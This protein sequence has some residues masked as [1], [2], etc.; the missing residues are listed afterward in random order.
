MPRGMGPA[1]RAG[2]AGAVIAAG[3]GLGA[4]NPWWMAAFIGIPLILAG[5]LIAPRPSR[6]SGL[7]TYRAGVSDRFVPA[8]V[9]ALTRSTLANEDQQPTLVTATI[10][11]AND[12]SY[13]ARWMTAMSRK[14]FQALADNPLTSLPPDGLPPRESR[15]SPDFDDHPGMRA[16]IYPAITVVTALAVL[17]A[18]G[19]VWRVSVRLP[20]LPVTASQIT[21]KTAN[22]DAR[23]D[24]M[25]RAITEKLG[26][27]AADNLLDLR[28]S[29][30]GS[31]YGSVLNPTNGESTTVYINNGRDTYTSATPN[32]LRKTSTFTARD[33]ASIQ[34]TTIAERMAQ[35]FRAVGNDGNLEDFQIK[36]SGPAKPIILTGKFNVPNTFPFPTTIQARPDGTVA[37]LFDPADFA[38]AFKRA[39]QALELAGI[40]ASDPVLTSF[41][42]RGIVRNTPHLHASTIQNSG[43]VLIEFRSDHRKGEAVV[44]PG[45]LPEVVDRSWGSNTPG[46]SF[47]D[48]SLT[49]FESVRRQA[50]HRGSLE[51]YESRAVDIEMSDETSDGRG[52]AIRIQ[53]AN[54]DAAAGTYSPTGEFLQPG[55]R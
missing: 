22:L 47:D 29:D 4:F 13:R 48:V 31:D 35:Q 43:G 55:T 19:D 50:M 7:T 45:E 38:E 42:I 3:I 32:T 36:R 24:N 27:G 26:P 10:S 53:L 14:D 6:I 8:R 34:L 33:V 5:L 11:P 28:F 37:E 41:Q 12:T 9:E 17:F 52:L 23:R 54:V 51:P 39:H 20:S 40:A 16:V 25:L 49:A 2:L 46:F 18:A 44:V 21:A 30:G 1:I 15:R